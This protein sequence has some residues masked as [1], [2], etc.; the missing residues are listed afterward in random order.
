LARERSS[1]IYQGENNAAEAQKGVG[2]YEL[3]EQRT[4]L[5]ARFNCKTGCI[6]DQILSYFCQEE[7][8]NIQH[9]EGRKKYSC[10]RKR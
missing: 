10:D 5:D 4:D 3:A 9:S 6:I 7:L 1:F 8:V 2:I